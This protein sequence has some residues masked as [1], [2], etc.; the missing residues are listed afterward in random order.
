MS[1]W[2]RRPPQEG[3]SGPL[4]FRNDGQRFSGT[5][6][7]DKSETRVVVE[8]FDTFLPTSLYFESRHDFD[9]SAGRSIWVRSSR[10]P[11][12]SAVLRLAGS[13]YANGQPNEIN[14]AALAYIRSM[15]W[16]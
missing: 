13:D 16:L 3:E 2:T 1:N 9:T 7:G 8:P 4:R 15:S 14:C 11:R 10:F 12:R 5:A 6:R